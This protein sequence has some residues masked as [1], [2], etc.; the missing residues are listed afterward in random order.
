MEWFGNQRGKSTCKGK[1]HRPIAMVNR[2]V[3]SSKS[4]INLIQSF[5]A[6]FENREEA[7]RHLLL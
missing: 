5:G 1:G 6:E 3:R 4:C 7:G 2:K